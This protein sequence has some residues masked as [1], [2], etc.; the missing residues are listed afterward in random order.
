MKTKKKPSRR[1]KKVVP[2]RKYVNKIFD[3]CIKTYGKSRFNRE[4]PEIMYRK[5]EYMNEDPRVMAFY[6]EEDAVIFIN[7]DDHHNLYQLANS[8]IHE[9]THYKQNQ[10]HYYILSQYLPYSKNPMEI[11]ANEVAKRDARKC[12]REI[13]G[14]QSSK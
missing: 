13:V 4:F 6:D 1:A 12:I 8:I 14:K 2:S 9:Y 3:W 11:E 7:K 5:A 10:H